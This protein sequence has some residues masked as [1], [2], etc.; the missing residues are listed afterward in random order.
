[1][2]KYVISAFLFLQELLVIAM[3]V[4]QLRLGK[5]CYVVRVGVNETIPKETN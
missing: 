2:R 5:S 3:S 4:T 1:M